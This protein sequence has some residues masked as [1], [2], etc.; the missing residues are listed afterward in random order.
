MSRRF[1]PLSRAALPLALAAA[2]SAPPPPQPA[3][4]PRPVVE[5]GR[6]AVSQSGH[7][8]GWL[9]LLEIQDPAGPLRFYRIETL[10]GQWLGHATLQGRFS[11]RVLFRDEEEDLGLHP[12]ARG[13]ELLLE[14][15]G[16]VAVAGRPDVAAVEAAAQTRDRP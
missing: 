3:Y 11:R 4:A 8:L 2:C 5:L 15:D 9:A 6:W 14:A 1:R 12:M 10:H 16:A 7:Q 13:L